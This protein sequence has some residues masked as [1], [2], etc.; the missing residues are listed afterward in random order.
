MPRIIRLLVCSVQFTLCSTF[1]TVQFLANSPSSI[2]TRINLSILRRIEANIFHLINEE[3]NAKRNK[4]SKIFY[5]AVSPRS[6]GLFFLFQ[7]CIVRAKGVAKWFFTNFLNMPFLIINCVLCRNCHTWGY[8]VT[9]YRLI[10]RQWLREESCGYM[11]LMSSSAGG[12][13][14][15]N[16]TDYVQLWIFSGTFCLTRWCVRL[17]DDCPSNWSWA[18]SLET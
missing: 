4:S 1:R 2:N 14:N 17:R 6:V 5:R 8:S 3:R 7:H 11:M 9:N 18:Q 13:C 10:R 12:M 16:W 15:G